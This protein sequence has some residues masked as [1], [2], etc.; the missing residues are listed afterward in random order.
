MGIAKL[1]SLC[2]HLIQPGF[3]MEQMAWTLVIVEENLRGLGAVGVF[4][5]STCHPEPY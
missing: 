5:Q 4:L 1:T 3:Q 2:L